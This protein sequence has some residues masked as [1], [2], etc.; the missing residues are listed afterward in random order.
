MSSQLEAFRTKFVTKQIF[1]LIT[2][3]LNLNPLKG[4]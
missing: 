3:M 2:N 1:T 4:D